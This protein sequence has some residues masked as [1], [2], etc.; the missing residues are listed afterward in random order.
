V[1]A[2]EYDIIGPMIALAINAAVT[3]VGPK[4][5]DRGR[6]ETRRTGD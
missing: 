5:T 1:T 3:V 2:I 6:A 4:L